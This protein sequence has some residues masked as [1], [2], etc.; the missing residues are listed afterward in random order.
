MFVEAVFTGNF[1]SFG[2][3][4]YFLESTKSLIDYR[5]D[6][7]AGPHN[8]P[9]LF[10][11]V[12]FAETIVLKSIPYQPNI[13]IVIKLKVELFVLGFVRPYRHWI[14]VGPK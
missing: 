1:C 3:M 12:D 2:P 5:F 6:V 4:I 8:A 11:I 7:R 13:Y 9:L 10:S 14:N